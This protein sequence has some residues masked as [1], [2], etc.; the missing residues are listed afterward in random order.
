[1]DIDFET[2]RTMA[3]QFVTNV[4]LITSDGPNGPNIAAIEW[5]YRV[6]TKPFLI[7][8]HLHLNDATTENIKQSKEF[9]ISLATDKQNVVSSVAGNYTGREIDKIAVLKELGTEFYK[10]KQINAPLVKGSLLNIECKVIKEEVL[11]DHMMFLG[12]VVE[13]SVNESEKPLLY[14]Q[15]KYWHVGDNIIKP[16]DEYLKKLDKIIE[17]HRRTKS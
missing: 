8:I 4:G 2:M 11:G 13:I 10:A 9:G 6:S 5:T 17:K 7:T 14:H 15:R 12:E 3:R 1:M 16:D